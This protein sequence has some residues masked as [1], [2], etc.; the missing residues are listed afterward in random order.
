[1]RFSQLQNL[2]NTWGFFIEWGDDS[3]SRPPFITQK[4]AP[5]RFRFRLKELMEASEAMTL[6]GKSS[7]DPKYKG[8]DWFHT[9]L[10]STNPVRSR[11]IAENIVALILLPK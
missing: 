7:G 8:T 9:A 1:Q 11:T 6:Y 3:Q 4:I 10:T 5:Y 2:L